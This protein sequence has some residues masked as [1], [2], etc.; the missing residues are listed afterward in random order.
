MIER[1][2]YLAL[3]RVEES[4]RSVLLKTVTHNGYRNIHALARSLGVKTIQILSIQ[5]GETSL[6]Q[7]LV[8]EAGELKERFQQM[9]Y[10]QRKGVTKAE[11][12]EVMGTHIPITAL[13]ATRHRICP[14][15]LL[16]GYMRSIQDIEWVD[17]C[18][19]HG[20][21]YITECPDCGNS[22]NWSKMR[23]AICDCDHEMS[24]KNVPLI[25][26]DASGSLVLLEYLRKRN[27]SAVMRLQKILIA[28]RFDRQSDVS[29]RIR[30]FNQ[31]ATIATDPTKG[32][33]EWL[34]DKKKDHQGIPDRVLLARF[35]VIDDKALRI[36]A[37]ALLE[38]CSPEIPNKCG[39]CTCQDEELSALET[40]TA[41]G[42]SA[43]TLLLLAKKGKV[44]K[45][46]V[47]NR[48]VEYPLASICSLYRMFMV[49]NCIDTKGKKIPLC[50]ANAFG[51]GIDTKLDQLRDGRLVL[52]H[53]D[54]RK[55]LSEYIVVPA[56]GATIEKMVTTPE[57]YLTISDT[58]GR[59]DVYPDAVRR[60]IKTGFISRNS[61]VGR[62][63]AVFV[64]VDDVNRFS[65][66]FVFIG[67][68]AKK[69]NAKKT[70]FSAQLASAGIKP[71]SGPGIDDGLVALYR[72]SDL[73][74]F[75]L[76]KIAALEKFQT[77]AG[78]KKG[79]PKIYDASQ[80]IRA[81]D[82]SKTLGLNV[83]HLNSVA[84]FGLLEEGVPPGRDSD[85]TR[86]YTAKSVKAAN[87]WLESSSTIEAVA[88]NENTTSHQIR[89]RFIQSGYVKPLR[90]NGKTLLS[91]EDVVR[92]EDHREIY[93]TCAEAATHVG[94]QQ[95][96]F[97]N[98]IKL[99][100]I[101][102]V[103]AEES[104]VDTITLLRWNDI[105]IE[106]T[107]ELMSAHAY[108]DCS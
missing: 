21:R 25:K 85:N 44:W 67:P 38:S 60:A 91:N 43:Q 105:K 63:N 9:F 59:L 41:M 65:K 77:K 32:M 42:V 88:E 13:L 40:E 100:K 92:I 52:V 101:A 47:R 62:F 90:L 84:N 37:E 50:Q 12:V 34:D 81:A 64:P 53:A 66:E 18:P 51:V 26:D 87:R 94:T 82:V 31:A 57:G 73:K 74:G 36:S 5:T 22:F 23:F 107:L 97:H 75:E 28:M 72:R 104:G 76:S 95:R 106:S 39:N 24:Y 103:P 15:C 17:V 4:P 71:V 29:K 33:R 58:A 14:E 48:G 11:P 7:E 10:R 20:C 69:Y 80:W 108:S 86:F 61:V 83:Q 3:P 93:C 8:I 16:D 1:L 2:H 55:P 19:Y 102:P 99:G 30:L 70:A 46:T 79:D 96:H 54:A 27:A 89:I 68:L 98:M 45:K 78:R 6:I 35:L 56:E 49:D